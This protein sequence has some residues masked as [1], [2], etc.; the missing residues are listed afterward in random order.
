M[1]F[2]EKLL[3][4]E[5]IVI[6]F[7][8]FPVTELRFSL[9]FAF[10]SMEM[11]LP[12]AFFLSVAG[13]ILPIIPLLFFLEPVSMKLRH[14]RLW[15]KFFDWFFEHTRRKAKL[16]E[17]FEAFGLMLFVAIPLPGSGVW[18]GALAATLF[19]IRF[20]YAFIAI[21][22]GVIGAGLI[23]SLGII[24][25]NAIGYCVVDWLKAISK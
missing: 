14:F 13:N 5:L 8:T 19:K 15:T 22:G 23:I 20:R 2:L 25:W 7:S 24:G 12:K 21:V 1:S 11:P 17:R 10:Y 18:T 4:K 6:I 16:V 3:S 9:P